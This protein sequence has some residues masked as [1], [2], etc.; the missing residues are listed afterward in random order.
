MSQ[1][2]LVFLVIAM[3][4]VSGLVIILTGHANDGQTVLTCIVSLISA[5]AGGHFAL[6]LP[7]EQNPKSQAPETIGAKPKTLS[8]E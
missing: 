5:S 3:S 8:G 4:L 7:G 2:K 6:S 1:T